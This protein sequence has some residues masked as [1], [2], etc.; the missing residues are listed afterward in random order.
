MGPYRIGQLN[1]IGVRFEFDNKIHATT[2]YE[3]QFKDNKLN[4]FGRKLT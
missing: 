2:I 3:G 4:G 1:G